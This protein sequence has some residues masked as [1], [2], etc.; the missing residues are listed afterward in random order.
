MEA[1]L[2]EPPFG[3]FAAS[4]RRYSSALLTVAIQT[5]QVFQPA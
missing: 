4:S 2:P 3:A 5:L 1:R